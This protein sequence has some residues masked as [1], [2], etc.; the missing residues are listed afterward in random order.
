MNR[1]NS[2]FRIDST[3]VRLVFENEYFDIA[4]TRNLMFQLKSTYLVNVIYYTHFEKGKRHKCHRIPF[5]L[6]NSTQL[7]KLNRRF[8]RI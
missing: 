1:C 7:K 8:F 6:R 3:R 5:N 2:P 4:A